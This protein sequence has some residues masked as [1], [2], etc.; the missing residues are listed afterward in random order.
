MICTLAYF[1]VS[2]G[3]G[4]ARTADGDAYLVIRMTGAEYEPC[5]GTA[6]ICRR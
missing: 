3:E 5:A 2:C 1:A 6:S 4:K